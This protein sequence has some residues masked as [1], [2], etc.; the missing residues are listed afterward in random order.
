MYSKLLLSLLCIG[1]SFNLLAQVE[2]VANY[3]TIDGRSNNL[4]N[5]EWGAANTN[6]LR[7]TPVGYSDG[8]SA[9]GGVN[10]PNPRVISNTFF[11]QDG[12]L[13]DPLNLSDYCWVWGQFLDHDIGLTP[14]A[15]NEVA[16]IPVPMGDPWFDPFG[17]GQV[18][19]PMS[20]S[21]SDPATG[22]DTNNP[23]QHTNVISTF[24]DG[25]AV[26]GSEEEQAAW[27]RSFEDGKLKVSAGNLLPFNTE[28]GL[29]EDPVDHDAPEMEDGVGLSEKLFVAGD[30]RA[31]ENVLLLSFH[32]LFVREHNRVCDELKEEHPD[33]TDEELYQHARK[34]VGGLIQSITFEEWLPA[35]GVHLSDY[36]G[37]QENVNPTLT[38]VFTAAAFR[39]GHTL[40]N[41]QILRVDDEGAFLP[42]GTLFLRDVFFNPMELINSGGLDPFLKGMATQIQQEFDG[43]IVDDVRNFLFGPP[44][45]GGLDLASININRGRER[46]LPG[47]NAVREAYGLASYSFFPE[48]NDNAQVFIGLQNLYGSVDEVDPWVGMLSEARMPGALIGPTLMTI[49]EQQ[50]EALRDGDRFYYEN[51]PI[52]SDAEKARIKTT[53]LHDVI[54]RNT[55]ITLMQD[56]V[57]QA[58]PHEEICSNMTASIVGAV[59]TEEGLGVADV[60]LNL[61]V[62]GETA[63]LYA[64]SEGLFNIEEIGSC[65]FESLNLSRGG[66]FINGVSTLDLVFIQKHIL[67][68]DTLGSSYKILAADVNGSG[69]ISTLDLVFIRR[70]ILTIEDS[71]PNE[72]P[73]W[74]LIPAD[75]EFTDPSDPFVDVIPEQF[76][77]DILSED[78][79][80]DF[81]AIKMGDVNGSANPLQLMEQEVEERSADE[82]LFLST[83]DQH[84]EAAKST[85]I[86]FWPSENTILEGLQFSLEYDPSILK[87]TGLG[88]DNMLKLNENDIAVFPEEGIVTLAWSSA[89]FIELRT[90][91]PVFSFVFESYTNAN[92]QGSIQISSKRTAAEAYIPDA[93]PLR[94]ALNVENQ[95][96]AGETF[97]VYQNYPN[98]FQLTTQIPFSLPEQGMV[99]LKVFDASGSL[100]V[101]KSR[102]FDKG[103]QSWQLSSQELSSKGLL[104][105]RLDTTYGTITRKMVY[106]H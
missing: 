9:L 70:L 15:P 62:A 74:R 104:Y 71:F 20:R 47:F 19:I 59:R 32:T 16:M 63:Q 12:L 55:G 79:E 40:L 69:S 58:M 98:P 89:T 97:K 31:N 29:L 28:T 26:Y 1:L 38:N 2:D 66:S 5:P 34:I 87:F 64:S 6:L 99:S 4:T 8:I 100:V 51:D 106:V 48:I 77:Y 7:F 75:F 52:L 27:L 30:V 60:A 18:L 83:R 25:S 68:I 67:N 46:G 84:F 85:E 45:A 82:T 23:R 96:I 3:R 73:A 102:I 57:F 81:I 42:G 14:D 22:T 86:T 17:T 54:M 10:R 49:L 53:T 37:Y 93:T 21:L 72:V 78:L 56:A 39:L 65:D 33:W 35:M 90:K 36:Q 92:V 61:S 91:L 95:D 88:E 43:K 44:G 103:E 94:L 105:Y 13:A 101:T 24:I 80:Q 41:S 50:F 76:D 11:A